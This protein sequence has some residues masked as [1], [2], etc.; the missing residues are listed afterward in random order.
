MFP[1]VSLIGL[2]LNFKISSGKPRPDISGQHLVVH[3][4]EGK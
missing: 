2:L 1:F 3:A 4:E